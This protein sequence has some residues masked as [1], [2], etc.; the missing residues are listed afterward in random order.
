M[1]TQAQADEEM[2]QIVDKMSAKK[3]ASFTKEL[4]EQIRQIGPLEGKS[5]SATTIDNWL[6]RASSQ[7]KLELQSSSRVAFQLWTM[8]VTKGATIT[9]QENCMIVPFSG[10][11][12]ELARSIQ[13]HF[14]STP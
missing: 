1:K 7:A 11:D 9:Q 10:F 5:I 12:E 8:L 6:R 13:Q 14:S 2:K 4:E 3:I